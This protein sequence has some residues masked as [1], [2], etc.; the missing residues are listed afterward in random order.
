MDLTK[1]G[2]KDIMLNLS[3]SYGF[4]RLTPYLNRILKEA[5]LQEIPRNQIYI[6]LYHI[7]KEHKDK[8]WCESHRNEITRWLNESMIPTEVLKTMWEEESLNHQQPKAKRN[9]KR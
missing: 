1:T 2:L 7:C 4:T 6:D 3:D 8:F 5:D 9:S